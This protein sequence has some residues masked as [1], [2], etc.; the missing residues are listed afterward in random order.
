VPPSKTWTIKGEKGMTGTVEQIG[1][2][3]WHITSPVKLDIGYGGPDAVPGTYVDALGRDQMV[4]I[5]KDVA[6]KGVFLDENYTGDLGEKW[7]PQDNVT[8]TYPNG[9][10]YTARVSVISIPGTGSLYIKSTP[11]EADII[12]NGQLQGVKTPATIT[13]LTAGSHEVKLTKTGYQVLTQTVTIIAGT[14]TNM[15]VSLTVLPGISTL[16]ISSAPAGARVFIDG[17][18]ALKVTPATITNLSSGDHTY[19]LVLSGYK[20][21]TGTFTMELGKNTIVSVV[22]TKP[23]AAVGTGTIL[24]IS[25]LGMGILG[26]VIIAT[27]RK[28]PE[29]TVPGYKGG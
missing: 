15:D 29:Y 14:T 22:M 19:K 9:T 28:K 6:S 5:E 7:Y 25:L 23:E 11:G 18:D 20:D 24:G 13:D 16:K 10:D 3:L 12:I 8:L 21:A 1:Y 26:A 2:L 4:A 27:R 17:A